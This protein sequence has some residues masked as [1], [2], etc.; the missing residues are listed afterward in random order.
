MDYDALIRNLTCTFGF[1]QR[2][3][4]S[5]PKYL[6]C[7]GK[8]VCNKCILNSCSEYGNVFK[9]AICKEPSKIKVKDDECMLESNEQAQSDLDRY[10]IDI[11]HYLLRRLDGSINNVTG[12]KI[13]K[14]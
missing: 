8:T 11:N 5:N 6:P 1:N 2:H 14:L 3:L 7:C 4:L 9:C 13:F 12:N 10:T